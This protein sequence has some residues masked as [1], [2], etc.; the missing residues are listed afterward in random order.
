MGSAHRLQN[1]HLFHERSPLFCSCSLREQEQ[2]QHRGWAQPITPRG[3]RSRRAMSEK[4]NVHPPGSAIAPEGGR[5]ALPI[6][7]S[8]SRS[9]KGEAHRAFY[10]IFSGLRP[11][12]GLF[13]FVIVIRDTYNAL[14]NF[15]ERFCCCL[16][17]RN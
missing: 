13:L 10:S 12:D 5:S 9:K 7:T 3:S 11:A 1:A 8:G 2:T 15:I 14:A 17:G 4:E 16:Y 6:A